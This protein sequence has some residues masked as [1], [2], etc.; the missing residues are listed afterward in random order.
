MVKFTRDIVGCAV[1]HNSDI[2]DMPQFTVKYDNIRITMFEFNQHEKMVTQI[3]RH[4]R[5]LK[6][7]FNAP[8]LAATVF[9]C[10]TILVSRALT[11]LK[12]EGYIRQ[13]GVTEK[14][15]KSQGGGSIKVWTNGKTDYVPD[16]LS[17]MGMVLG[18]LDEYEGEF[19]APQLAKDLGKRTLTINNIFK[20]LEVNG[21]IIKTAMIKGEKGKDQQG[22][23]KSNDKKKGCPFNRFNYRKPNFIRHGRE[24]MSTMATNT[25]AV[26]YG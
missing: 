14:K 3:K 5:T 9:F 25:L 11:D 7:H 17:I 19:T 4:V 1:K 12:A 22:Y 24:D 23:A 2:Y 21:K 20:S 16:D 18:Y 10:E 8:E 26:N 15:N 6:Y 13:C